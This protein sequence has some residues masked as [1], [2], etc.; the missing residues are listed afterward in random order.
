MLLLALAPSFFQP[1]PQGVVTPNAGET[2]QQSLRH[3]VIGV[4]HGLV[5]NAR[6]ILVRNSWGPT[7][8]D[9]G[10]GWLPASFV[11][12]GLF[13]LAVLGE[14]VNVPAYSIAA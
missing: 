10:Y 4:G 5:D 14:E 1:S 7:W 13:A 12:A 9:Q 2:P 3:A 11:T 8:G 6:A